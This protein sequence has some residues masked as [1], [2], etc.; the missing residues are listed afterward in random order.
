MLRQRTVGSLLRCRYGGADGSAYLSVSK[1]AASDKSV[2]MTGTDRG[3]A[4][5]ATL[6]RLRNISEAF[7]LT[8]C[9]LSRKGYRS[10]STT[11]SSPFDF[12]KR[13]WSYGQI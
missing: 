11:G 3:R 12:F 2:L 13:Q 4:L 5:D 7:A 9:R 8:L 10:V 6:R 1:R